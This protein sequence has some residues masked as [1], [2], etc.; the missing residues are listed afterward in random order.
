MTTTVVAV[1]VVVVVVVGFVQFAS[2]ACC[3]GWRTCRRVRR[4]ACSCSDRGWPTSCGWTTASSCSSTA[5]CP[6]CGT[7]SCAGVAS[8]A[9]TTRSVSASARPEHFLFFFLSFF[10][11]TTHHRVGRHRTEFYGRLPSSIEFYGQLPSIRVNSR[12]FWANY[13]V[14]PSFTANY[15]VLG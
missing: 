15:R 2:R 1:V 9:T 4:A 3:G 6:A 10:L 13:R 11:F 5:P 8:S 14:L 7:R 12:V